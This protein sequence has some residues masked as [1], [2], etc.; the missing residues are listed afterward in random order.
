MFFTPVQWTLWQASGN[1]KSD[2]TG[3]ISIDSNFWWN[4]GGY[5]S[6]LDLTKDN[7]I[8]CRFNSNSNFFFGLADPADYNGDN[9]SPFGK[10]LYG[11]H[12]G[13]SGAGSA[14]VYEGTSRAHFD[15]AA[16]TN[17]YL[18]IVVGADGSVK[19]YRGTT[20]I[21]TSL[22]PITTDLK[23]VFYAGY[24]AGTDPA[25]DTQPDTL[26]GNIDESFHFEG[27]TGGGGGSTP[28]TTGQ[29]FPRG[30]R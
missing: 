12:S 5:S 13:N 10:M 23:I 4:Q 2:A 28:V 30:I 18:S 3:A 11:F 20:L 21:Y 22:T 27:D 19:Y 6:T 14:H 1:S 25:Y 16:A 7:I 15:G 17:K 9:V 29:L 8:V 26:A 24:Y